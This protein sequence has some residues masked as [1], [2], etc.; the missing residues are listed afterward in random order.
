MLKIL[1]YIIPTLDSLVRV[2]RRVKECTNIVNL[3]FQHKDYFFIFLSKFFQRSLTVLL[4]YRKIFII[5]CE[6]SSNSFSCS[7]PKEHYLSCRINIFSK[8]SY[9][10]VIIFFKLCTN[11]TLS[12]A[13]TKV[14]KSSSF[15]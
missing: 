12:F 7:T 5:F 8:F 6:A 13:N 1:F 4:H 2:S 11:L 14:I 15:S 9:S 10:K 3:F